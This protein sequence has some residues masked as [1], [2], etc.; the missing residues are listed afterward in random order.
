MTAPVGPP[1]LGELE[2]A[3]MEHLWATRSSDVETAHRSVGRSRGITLNTIQS[4]LQR[5]YRKGLLTRRKVSH[6]YVYSPHV[7]REEVMAQLVSEVV[8]TFSGGR[9]EPMLA[10]FVDLASRAGRGT[11]ERLEQM[12]E[13]KRDERAR[14]DR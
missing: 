14:G 3:M 7:S 12:I 1:F 11:L 6:A 9:P 4:T 8:T 5:L 13:R 2:I 10:T